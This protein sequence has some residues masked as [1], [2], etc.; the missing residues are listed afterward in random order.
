MHDPD[1][2]KLRVLLVQ[3][4]RAAAEVLVLERPAQDAGAPQGQ[5]VVAEAN[6]AGLAQ[7]R[8]LG[9]LLSFHAAGDGGEEAD[10]NAGLLA[11]RL[12]QGLDVRGR[13]DRRIG[14]GHRQDAAVATGRGGAG[15][16]LDVLL[17]LVPRRAQVDV[18]I[19]ERGEGMQAGG[20]D[21]LRIG[22]FGGAGGVSSAMW[23]S[24]MTTSWAPSIP[25]TGSSTCAP[26]RISSAPS[27]ERMSS[28]AARLTRVDLSGS[29]A[30]RPRPRPEPDGRGRPAARRGSPSARSTRRRPAGRSAT[31]A[32]RPRPRRARRRG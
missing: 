18:R 28:A 16:G 30:R 32:S 29:V 1:P 25:A 11:R 31:A 10:R 8:H 21:L 17:V 26:R 12:A 7:C 2:R 6:R 14:V 22:D 19:E 5:A 15:A 13:R 9:Q 23:P 20:I 27:P 3:R 24:R 4:D